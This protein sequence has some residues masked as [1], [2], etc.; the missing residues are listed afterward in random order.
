MIIM[1]TVKT[2]TSES[3]GITIRINYDLCTGAAAC[4][5]ECPTDVYEL[6]DGKATAPNIDE[7]TECSHQAQLLLTRKQRKSD[8]NIYFG[9]YLRWWDGV[10]G[11]WAEKLGGFAMLERH[12]RY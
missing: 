11:R 12:G 1:A 7:C 9:A 10:V 6:V 4:V 2:Y 5:D 3:L 8:R